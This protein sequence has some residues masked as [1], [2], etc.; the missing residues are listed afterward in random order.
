MQEKVRKT[1]SDCGKEFLGGRNQKR[2]EECRAEHKAVDMADKHRAA[3]TRREMKA[4]CEKSNLAA[5][6][7]EA[8]AHNMSYGKWVAMRRLSR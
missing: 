1:C 3:K 2:C 6:I 4:I 7:A 8:K 5:I